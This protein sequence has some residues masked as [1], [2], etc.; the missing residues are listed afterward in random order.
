MVFIPVIG[1]RPSL[2]LALPEPVTVEE[3]DRGLMVMRLAST[4]YGTDLAFEI[5]DPVREEACKT[6]RLDYM[7]VR[8]EVRL[9]D[10]AGAVIQ[11][12]PG[13]GNSYSFGQHS[14]GVFGQKVAFAPL[15]SGASRV[16]LEV[17][18]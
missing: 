6:G 18:G 7:R 14:F 2:G 16:T 10:G 3:N 5:R 12:T 17:R 15:P 1:F 4:E 13:P 11:Q 8:A 9:R